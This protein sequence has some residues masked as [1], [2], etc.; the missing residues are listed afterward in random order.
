MTSLVKPNDT[1][2][3]MYSTPLKLEGEALLR[4]LLPNRASGE[5]RRRGLLRLHLRHLRRRRG[6]R[7]RLALLPGDSIESVDISVHSHFY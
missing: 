1:E 7:A 5:E 6:G 2:Q 3:A 4:G